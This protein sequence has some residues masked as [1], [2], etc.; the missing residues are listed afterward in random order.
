VVTLRASATGPRP[1]VRAETVPEGEPD[2]GVAKVLDTDVWVAGERVSA[3]VYDRAR[4]VSGAVVTGPAIITEMDSTTLVLPDHA[5]EVH[6][7][8]SLLITPVSSSQEG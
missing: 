8:G 3:G 2:P 6:P 7:S 4:L 5:A 1:N